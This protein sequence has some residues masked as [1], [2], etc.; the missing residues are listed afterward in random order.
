MYYVHSIVYGKDILIQY[1]QSRITE[2]NFERIYET[3][4]SIQEM[5]QVFASMLL[6]KN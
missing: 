6:G 5:Y 1:N 4:Q 2:F 3:I